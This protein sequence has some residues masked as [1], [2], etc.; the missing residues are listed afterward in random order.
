MNTLPSKIL[1]VDDD[2][3]ITAILMDAVKILYPGATVSRTF[4]ADNALPLLESKHY[5]LLITDNI[6]PGMDGID[7]LEIVV[8]KH[9]ETRAVMVTAFRNHALLKR[10]DELGGIDILPKPFGLNDLADVLEPVW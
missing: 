10:L 7:M 8:E 4:T 9:P 6:M 1:I 5:D 3:I 2:P